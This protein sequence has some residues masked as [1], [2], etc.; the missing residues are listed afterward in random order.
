MKILDKSGIEMESPDLTKGYLKEERTLVKHHEAIE[1]VPDEG[2]WEII[3]E[4]PNGGKDAVFVAD[5]PGVEPKE[6][7]DEYETVLRYT[8]YTPEELA[9]IEANRKPTTEEQIAE[10]REA[11]DLLLSGVTE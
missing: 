1:Y 10:L 3:R 5:V 8:P 2:H 7:W 4:Y 6:A 11:L 9:E